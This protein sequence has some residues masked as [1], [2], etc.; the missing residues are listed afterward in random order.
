MCWRILTRPS[1]CWNWRVGPSSDAQR[2]VDITVD[3]ESAG[4]AAQAD[5][6][7]ARTELLQRQQLEL[8]AEAELGA[9]EQRYTILTGLTLKPVGALSETAATDTALSPDHPTL[10]FLQSRTGYRCRQCGIDASP[11]QRQAEHESRDEARERKP[12][13][14]LHRQYR[15]VIQRAVWE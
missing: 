6:L 7:Q 11:G 5:I 9:A 8:Q 3:M 12:A 1:R 15:S 10:D 2:L 13:A 14:T 4:A